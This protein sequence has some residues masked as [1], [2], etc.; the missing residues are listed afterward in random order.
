VTELKS[1]IQESLDVKETARHHLRL[2]GGIMATLAAAAGYALTGWFYTPLK[3]EAKLQTPRTQ[4]A[5]EIPR[6]GYCNPS[7]TTCRV[8]CS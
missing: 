6:I 5:L 1:K 8:I 3:A 4:R 7:S 2:V